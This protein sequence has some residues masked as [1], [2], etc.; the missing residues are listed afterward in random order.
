M[1]AVTPKVKACGKGDGGV[2][3]AK[4]TMAGATGRVTGV[5]VGGITDT[6]VKTCVTREVSKAKVPAFSNPTFSVTYPFKL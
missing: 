4:I 3:M 6:D 1:T 2:A 5:D